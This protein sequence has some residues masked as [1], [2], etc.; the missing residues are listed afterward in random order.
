MPS[1]LLRRTLAKTGIQDLFAEPEMMGRD[2][3]EL[4][5]IHIL[6]RLLQA[7]DLW[8]NEPQGFIRAGGPG[9]GQVLGLADIDIDIHCL[10]ALYQVL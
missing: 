5:R 10:A 4:V 7:H 6:D 1:V 9:I 3:E 2:F 8:R